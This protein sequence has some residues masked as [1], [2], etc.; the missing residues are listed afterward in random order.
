MARHYEGL[1]L[2]ALTL[3]LG[4]PEESGLRATAWKVLLGY[5]PADKR[6]WQ[7]TIHDQRLS[8]YVS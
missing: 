6:I 7:S 8:Y 1:R 3:F 2:V 5:L 4:I